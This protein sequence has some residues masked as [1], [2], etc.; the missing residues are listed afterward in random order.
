MLFSHLLLVST[1]LLLFVFRTLKM[2]QFPS[3]SSDSS[4]SCV[5]S[6]SSTAQRASVICCGP[7][8]SPSRWVTPRSLLNSKSFSSVFKPS[9]MDF[10]DLC[11][12]A[13]PHVALLIVMLFF[14]Y[15][16]IGMQVHSSLFNFPVKH[17]KC[18]WFSNMF[19][20]PCG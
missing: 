13:L 9:V 12:Q 6:S 18:F 1:P 11:P 5:W 8:S 17:C 15:A 16:V 20:R 10:C 14:I 19:L 2:P 7:S 4:V 3:H